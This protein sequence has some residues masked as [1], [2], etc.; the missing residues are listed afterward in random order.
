MSTYSITT[1]RPEPSGASPDAGGVNF[2]VFSFHGEAV[3]LCLFD[4]A[5]TEF[6]RLPLPERTQEGVWY[7][8][9]P[10]LSAGA[11]YG[12][13]VEGPWAPADGHLFN[14]A[15]LLIDPYARELSG[16]LD[17][18]SD[19]L[20][21][22]NKEDSAPFVPKSV[23]RGER[24]TGRLKVPAPQ[25]RWRDTVIYETHV[26]GLTVL[27]PEVP[28]EARGRFS[29]AGA[30]PVTAHL[31][32]MGVTAV[33]FL[34]VF[35]CGTG[36]HLK[37]VSGL[38]NY[39]GYDPVAFFAPNPAYGT[40]SEFKEMVDAMHAAGLQVILD[41][42]YNHTGEGDENG[43]VISL[44]GLD[45]AVY[46]RLNAEGGYAPGTGCGNRL[47]F[48]SPQVVGLVVD[49]LR[50]W[51]M[52]MGVDGFR[53]D[54]APVHGRGAEDTF[55]SGA[56][57]FKAVEAD[58]VLS[59]LKMIA[60]PWD[61]GDGGY[62]LGNFPAPW[63]EWNGKYKE[64]VRAFWAGWEGNAPLLARRFSGSDDIQHRDEV[65]TPVINY[66]TVHDGFTLWD[67]VS[68]NRKHNRE[69][70]EGNRDGNDVTFSWNSGVEGE[71]EDPGIR[72]LRARRARSLLATV[73]LS[74][75]VPMFLGGDE[76]FH[77]QG[78]NN[79]PY[80]Q[81]NRTS[82]Y[83]WAAIDKTGREQM[84]FVQSL[85]ALRAAHPVLA[86]DSRF[87]GRTVSG[88]RAPDIRWLRPDGEEMGD[89]DWQA[90]FVRSLG[91]VINGD[92][93]MCSRKE[94]GGKTPDDDFLI[95]VNAWEEEVLWHFPPAPKRGKWHRVLDTASPGFSDSHSFSAGDEWRLEGWTVT[96][97]SC[98]HQRRGND[99][100]RAL[101]PDILRFG[102]RRA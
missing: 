71:T 81:D 97:F 95:L 46:Y 101:L 33:E 32:A 22:G 100:I 90:G 23:V 63:R 57:F 28:S 20:L 56:P 69:N 17:W 84:A 6:Q 30:G 80:C 102:K 85:A 3:M 19:A 38:S 60:E 7:G 12:Y 70:G 47:D 21:P 87:N 5:G 72:A 2:S 58:P 24:D 9:V 50:Y 16:T 98:P 11:R 40:P 75:G 39:W 31:Q 52:E 35:A 49:S 94:K 76:F 42:V 55:S 4:S 25:I 51:A 96:V 91:M 14:S 66:V 61:L 83:D 48:S 74:R 15:K 53:F 82:W 8:Y 18:R 78:G 77:A 79:N 43:P 45:N 1:G 37:D 36:R 68:Y 29:G 54:L 44:K 62:Q 59:R 34:P 93:A 86:S 65:A 13:R 92:A 26:K 99:R 41:V 64:D 10:G 27:H 73:F 67:L 89:E 88:S